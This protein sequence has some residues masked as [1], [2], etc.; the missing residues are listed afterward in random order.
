[1]LILYNSGIGP[2]SWADPEGLDGENDRTG[3]EV[4]GQD[5]VDAI[6]LISEVFTE[7]ATKDV[8]KCNCISELFAFRSITQCKDELECKEAQPKPFTRE[9]DVVR[10]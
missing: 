1:M 3:E 2:G 10:L 8:H 6:K 4:Q 5:T 7:N 9:I